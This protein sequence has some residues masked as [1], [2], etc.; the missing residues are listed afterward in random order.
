MSRMTFQRILDGT[1]SL[2][3]LLVCILILVQ[4]AR[5]YGSAPSPAPGNAPASARLTP[6]DRL[7]PVAGLDFSQS[8]RTLV[9][10]VQSSCHFCSESMAFYRELSQQKTA[11]VRLVVVAPDEPGTAK[12]YVESNRFAPDAIVSSDLPAIGVTGTPTLLL[13][14][15]AGVIERVWMGKLSAARE[16]EVKQA[17]AEVTR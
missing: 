3:V 1:T 5:S 12:A 17:L 11:A 10:A 7:A 16:K 8:P 15:P 14:N 9:M 6:G 13:V 4:A 2:A